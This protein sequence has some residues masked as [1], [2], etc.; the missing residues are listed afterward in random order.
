MHQIVY[1]AEM[2]LLYWIVHVA[3]WLYLS[4]VMVGEYTDLVQNYLS[5][6]YSLIYYILPGAISE[7]L[8]TC[9]SFCITLYLCV[10]YATITET[11]AL[12]WRHRVPGKQ[13]VLWSHKK[14]ESQH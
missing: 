8:T 10:S 2:E 7:R 12:D 11:P 9:C 3:M 6:L 1:E 14:M 4:W 5:T 13:I